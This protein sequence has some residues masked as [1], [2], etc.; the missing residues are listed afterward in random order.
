M[1]MSM[2]P[3]VP[4]MGGQTPQENASSEPIVTGLV[5]VPAS[6]LGITGGPPGLMVGV[7]IINGQPAL[8]IPTMGP[9]M[10]MPQA[11]GAPGIQAP[12]MQM[13]GM[14]TG[15]PGLPGAGG[16]PTPG[17]PPPGIAPM[18]PPGISMPS[19]PVPSSF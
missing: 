11:G 19:M 2:M 8:P 6:A 7:P 10:M 18:P 14:Q 4:T 15:V 13:P 5:S 9:G 1:G 12:G 3:P 17:M 16:M